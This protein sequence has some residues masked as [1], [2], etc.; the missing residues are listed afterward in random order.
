M[1]VKGRSG[2]EVIV[3]GDKILVAPAESFVADS[4]LS[5]SSVLFNTA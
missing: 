5:R 4:I 2:K 3:A 1:V